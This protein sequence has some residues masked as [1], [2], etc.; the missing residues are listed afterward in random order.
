[1]FK[2]EL[3]KMEA[4]TLI[5][6]ENAPLFSSLKSSIRTTRSKLIKINFNFESVIIKYERE[7]GERNFTL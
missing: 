2:K 6:T 5:D 7:K 4:A 1:M 3:F